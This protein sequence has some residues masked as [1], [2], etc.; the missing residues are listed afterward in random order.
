MSDPTADLDAILNRVQGKATAL[1]N[2]IRNAL[3][4]IKHTQNT[5]DNTYTIELP[6]TSRDEVITIMRE[7]ERIIEHCHR[8]SSSTDTEK[9]L[10]KEIVI[11]VET[12]A[13]VLDVE[14]ISNFEGTREQIVK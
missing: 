5:A 12:L 10:L 3:S 4:S 11:L 8:K 7:A 6:T 14:L 2:N 13:A 1:R 9:G